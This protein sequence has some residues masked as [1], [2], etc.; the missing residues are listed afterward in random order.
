MKKP[1]QRLAGR[2]IEDILGRGRVPFLVGG[3]PL[4]VR[5]VVDGLAIPPVPPNEELRRQLEQE[6]AAGGAAA[7]HEELRAL[8]A[9]AAA[10]IQP[11]NVRRVIRAIEVIRSSGTKFS[12]LQRVEPPRYR[13]LLIALTMPREE[14]FRR[15]DERVEEMLKAGW[16]AEVRSL[17]ARGYSPE[18]PSMSSHG[19]RA[20]VSYLLGQMDLPSAVQS[21]K[22]DVHRYIRHQYTWFRRDRR[23]HWVD[24]AV[25]G[26]R[27]TV[28]ALVRGW[29]G[30]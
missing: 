10:R 2:A 23:I 16:V 11:T 18:L 15:V 21:I 8:D 6:A 3:S 28:D 12:D 19:Y 25:P 9:E 22:W 7:L 1:Y 20:I 29:L 17:L 5:A 27:E 24:V 26:Y 13:T 30:G 4:Y 14:L